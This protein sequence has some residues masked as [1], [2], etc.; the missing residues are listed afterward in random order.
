MTDTYPT[1]SSGGVKRAEG[2]T[3]AWLASATLLPGEAL[4]GTD[5]E[6]FFV[7]H[8]ARA[9]AAGCPTRADAAL[10]KGSRGWRLKREPTAAADLTTAQQDARAAA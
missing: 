3:T 2:C 9:Q 1:T 6:E 7:Q 4:P 8:A 10:A 5:G